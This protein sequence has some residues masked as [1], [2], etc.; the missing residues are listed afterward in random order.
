MEINSDIIIN[1]IKEGEG[2][3]LDFKHSINDSR[4]IA[5]S[6]SAFAN[7][8]GGSLLIGVRDNGS[9]KGVQSEEEYFMVET[10]AQIF[11]KPEVPF[12]HKLWIVEGKKVLEIIV[13]QGKNKPYYAPDEK[14]EYK[15]YVRNDDQNLVAGKVMRE[16]WKR[17]K[18]GVKGGKIVYNSVL[19]SLFGYIDEYGSISRTEFMSLCK[20]KSSTATNLLVN[21]ILMDILE[22]VLSEKGARFCYTNNFIESDYKINQ[23][24][25]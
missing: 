9:I 13:N 2:Q 25:L 17:K 15:A 4:K 7:T 18:K 23:D 1:R 10:A 21:L 5:R 22:F 20:I 8:D 24:K 12:N 3:F 14:G 6:L 19:M 11:C 16:V